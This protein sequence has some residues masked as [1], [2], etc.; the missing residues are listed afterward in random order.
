M[1]WRD[2]AYS[3][4]GSIPQDG[5]STL[6]LQT[7]PEAWVNPE[8]IYYEHEELQKNRKAVVEIPKRERV[9]KTSSS[10]PRSPL[11]DF[12]ENLVFRKQT[13][14]PKVDSRGM[15]SYAD[16]NTTSEAMVAAVTT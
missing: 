9:I 12:E 7:K 3:F 16:L 5:G 14:R 6:L 1:P 4:K 15:V 10:P 8:D 11:L 13:K 2:M